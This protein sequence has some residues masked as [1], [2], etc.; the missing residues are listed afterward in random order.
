MAKDKVGSWQFNELK[1][2]VAQQREF[3]NQMLDMIRQDT[4]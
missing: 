2:Q 1:E 4:A 3:T